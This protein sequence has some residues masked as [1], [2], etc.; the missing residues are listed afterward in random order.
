M[1][2]LKRCSWKP[3]LLGKSIS[4]CRQ[5]KGPGRHNLVPGTL[6]WGEPLALQ[7]LQA[8]V[9]LPSS[10]RV[11]R[12]P[13]P[14]PGSLL[15]AGPPSPQPRSRSKHWVFTSWLGAGHRP[16]LLELFIPIRAVKG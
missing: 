2:V 14:Q 1:S 16:F 9:R 8:G 3:Y 7:E 4:S 15:Q 6:R 11:K 12:A 5:P 13:G 10:Q